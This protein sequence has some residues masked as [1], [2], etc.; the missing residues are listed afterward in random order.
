MAESD[1]YK[2]GLDKVLHQTY[3]HL[4]QALHDIAED[5][6]SQGSQ[7]A[8]KDTGAL[9]AS[10]TAEAGYKIDQIKR[11]VSA[12]V[13]ARTSYAFEQHEN[14]SFRHKDGEAKY[15][16]KPY[17]E[18]LSRYRETIKGFLSDALTASK[19]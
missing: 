6:A 9:R 14:L 18:R 1:S 10:I 11:Q 15:L 16:T 17:Q 12:E 13:V 4:G 5:I 8:P 3:A 2:E 19:K 7:R